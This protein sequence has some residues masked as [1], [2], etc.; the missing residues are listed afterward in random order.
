[1][2]DSIR[3]KEVFTQLA[4][5]YNNLGVVYFTAARQNPKMAQEYEAKALLY[6]YEAKNMA[7]KIGLL[8]PEAEYNIKVVLNKG[9]RGRM[10]RLDETIVKR[11]SLQKILEELK[12]GMI[13][14][15]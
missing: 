6:F 3:H 4:R 13:D 14:T 10:A 8:Y 1:N 5:A 12:N 2:P 15:L 7:N 11:T 9:V